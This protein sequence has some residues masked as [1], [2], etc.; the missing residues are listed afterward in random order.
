[1][2]FGSLALFLQEPMSVFLTLYMLSMCLL[3]IAKIV[4]SLLITF[5]NANLSL[6]LGHWVG[7]AS[8]NR[9]VQPL[10]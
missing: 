3:N 7:P 4:F 9:T 2:I 10:R 1:M 6:D 8:L 5:L